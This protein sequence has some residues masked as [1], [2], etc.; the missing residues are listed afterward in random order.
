MAVVKPGH[1]AYRQFGNP[2]IENLS[3]LDVLMFNEK[4]QVKEFLKMYELVKN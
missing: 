2:F 1:A 3:I 4:E